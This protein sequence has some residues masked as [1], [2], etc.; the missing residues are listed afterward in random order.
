LVATFADWHHATNLTS[1][2]E[3]PLE[4][5]LVSAMNRRQVQVAP[6]RAPAPSWRAQTSVRVAVKALAAI[7]WPLAVRRQSP[8]PFFANIRIEMECVTGELLVVDDVLHLDNPELHAL[9]PCLRPEKKPAFS[10]NC[11]PVLVSTRTE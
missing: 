4:C 9:E 6:D 2:I 7:S 1:Y 11:K 3:R 10:V 8:C 5:P